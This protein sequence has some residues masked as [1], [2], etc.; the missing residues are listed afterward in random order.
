M[1]QYY[2]YT[3]YIDNENSLVSSV[4]SELINKMVDAYLKISEAAKGMKKY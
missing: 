3:N 2:A 1:G 4:H